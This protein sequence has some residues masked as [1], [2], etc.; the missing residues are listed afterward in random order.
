M[1]FALLFQSIT[2][3]VSPLYILRADPV[4]PFTKI[5][6]PTT[7]LEVLIL[8]TVILTLIDFIKSGAKIR[9]LRTSFDLPIII[10]LLSAILAVLIS[11]DFKGGLGILKAYFIEPILF[12]YCLIYQLRKNNNFFIISSLFIAGIWVSALSLVQKVTGGFTLAPHEL[13]QGRVSAV[14]NSAN[15][16][17]LFLGPIIIL[18]FWFFLKKRF[19]YR[20]IGLSVLAFFLLDFIWTK[21]RGGLISLVASLIIFMYFFTIDRYLKPAVSLKRLKRIWF[22]PILIAV[23]ASLIFLSNFYQKTNFIPFNHG[24]PYTQGDTLQI[25]YFIWAGTMK[26]L[27]DNFVFGVGL[28]GFKTVY[29]NRYRLPQ[30]QE[31]FQY[32]HNL[33]LTFW[34]EMGLFGLFAF[35]L[36]IVRSFRLIIEKFLISKE[37]NLFGI[38]LL[39]IL[40]Y[41]LIHGLVDVPY[42]KND[43]SLQFWI[44]ISMINYWIESKKSD[45]KVDS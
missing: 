14:Y 13:A 10:F 26:M 31:Q 9:N 37:N 6:I 41:W 34:T 4:I 28:N 35:L 7:F 36:I 25:R 42:F 15:S 19:Q 29:T 17:A 20:I 8:F 21:S 33:L 5:Q 44:I 38:T 45:P 23:I 24:Q 32:P 43:L 1:N 3:I 2:I 39:G 40:S 22:V 30:Y 27:K 12:Y 18:S 11:V 16:L